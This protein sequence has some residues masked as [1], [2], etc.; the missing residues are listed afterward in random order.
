MVI[1]TILFDVGT[2]LNDI[3][4]NVQ[5]TQQLANKSGFIEIMSRT[6]CP[7]PDGNFQFTS[8]IDPSSL[9][10]SIRLGSFGNA[11]RKDHGKF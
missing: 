4:S 1:L 8:H 11:G 6:H 9:L 7:H 2:S 10:S 3:A 5:S